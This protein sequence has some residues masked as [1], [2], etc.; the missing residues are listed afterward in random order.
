MSSM[1]WSGVFPA[2]TTQF[3][4]DLSV[5]IDAS[6]QVLDALVR[7]G[8]HGLVVLGTCGENNS[9]EADEKR[10]VLQAAVEVVAGRV[11]II[12]GVSELT[13]SRAALFAKDAEALGADALMVL[14]AMVYVPTEAEL[15]AH[16]RTVAQA[17]ALPI[18]LYNNPPAYRAAITLDVLAGLASEPTIV[19]VKESAP[20]TRRFTDLAH[21]FGDRFILMA[22][23]DD[24]A[25]EGLLMGARGWVSGLTSAFPQES[26]AL[27]AA[28]DRGDLE[29]ARRIYRWFMPLLHLDAEHD[30]VQSIKLAEQIMGRGSERVRMPRLPLAGARRAQVIAMVEE[31]AATRPLLTQ[32]AA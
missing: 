8:V 12:V 18:M 26:V 22:G 11:P 14:P 13:T 4:A 17:S 25:L 30:L 32:A 2:A 31:A 23:L 9:L 10:Q 3:N 15:E 27:V 24:V 20:D 21:A 1:N 6:Q 7:D 5:D 19:A 29:E 28:V 16:F